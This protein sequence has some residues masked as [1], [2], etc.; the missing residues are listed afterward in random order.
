MSTRRPTRKTKRPRK[1]NVR[2]QRQQV[3]VVNPMKTPW[4][5]R[6]VTRLDYTDQLDIVCTSGVLSVYTFNSNGLYDP[7]QTGTGHQPL[8]FDQ[9]AAQ[10][11]RYRVLKMDYLV[12]FGNPAVSYSSYRCTVAHVNGSTVPSNP[13]IF[14]VPYSSQGAVS[15]YGPPLRLRGSFN[16]TKLNSDPQKYRVDDR[17]SALVTGNPTEVMY[18]HLGIMPNATATIRVHVKFVYHVEFYDIETP[19]AS[20]SG[21]TVEYY[22]KQYQNSMLQKAHVDHVNSRVAPA[23]YNSH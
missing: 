10:Y 7:D 17:Y 23:L 14:E 6:T 8:G 20:V 16:L 22:K 1:Q 11:N 9:Y 18:C 13:A 21:H 19:G 2:R 4:P 3:S 12:V 5:T 15:T